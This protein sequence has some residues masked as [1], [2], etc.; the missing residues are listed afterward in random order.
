MICIML[1]NFS[2]IVRK[3]IAGSSLPK[4]DSHFDFLE[5]K[6]IKVIIN[7][8]RNPTSDKFKD[9]FELHHLEIPD[10]GTPDFE[11]ID[12]FWNIYQKAEEESKPVVV[13]C[14]AGCG[15]TGLVLACWSLLSKKDSNAEDAISSIRKLRPCS[16][17]IT[18]QEV[19]IREYESYR[20]KI[21]S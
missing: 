10:F 13:H 12:K 19:F 9:R 4:T 3:K 2:W 1:N 11:L 20:R 21:S 16:I 7:L 5:F 6:G 14:F 17:E 8:T 15:R 18:E